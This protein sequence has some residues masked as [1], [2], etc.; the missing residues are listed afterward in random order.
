[1][2]ARL[3]PVLLGLAAALA[4]CAAEPPS[5]SEL[6]GTWVHGDTVLEFA[7]DGTFTLTDAPDYTLFTVSESWRESD[8]ATRDGFGEWSLEADAVRL[9]NEVGSGYGEKLFYGSEGVLFF[10]LD[11][12][13][14]SPRCFELVRED[15]NVTPK[16]PEDCFLRP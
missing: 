9:M 10:G 15:S 16:G 7:D 3:A 8:E 2:R 12:G 11:M 13:S 5:E 6:A 14:D 4:G 1:V